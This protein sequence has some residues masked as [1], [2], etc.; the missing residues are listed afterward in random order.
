M[1]IRFE[2]LGVLQRLAGA[3]S[4]ALDAAQSMTVAEA[5]EKLALRRPELRAEL[6]RCAVARGDAIV[7]RRDAVA[8][9]TTLALLPPVAGG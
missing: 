4:I 6:E 2:M 3:D 9:G 5:L 7:T 8:P 1:Q